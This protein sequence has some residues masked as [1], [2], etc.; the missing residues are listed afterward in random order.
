MTGFR[1]VVASTWK[2][3]DP[4][5]PRRVRPGRTAQ[6]LLAAGA[7]AV[8]VGMT[9]PLAA[10]A[11][12]VASPTG[13]VGAAA[14]SSPQTS[15]AADAS[16]TAANIPGWAIGPFTPSAANPLLTPSGSGYQAAALYNP[17]VLYRD[18]QYKMLYRGQGTYGGPSQIGY[19]SS[20]DGVHFTEDTAANPVINFGTTGEQ[21]KCGLEDPRLLELQGTY[22]TF[23][24]SVHP[25]ADGTCYGSYDISESTS[26]DG[27]HWST[28]WIVEPNAGSN[29]DAAVVT[30]ANGTPTKV[31]GEYVMYF[32]QGDTGTDIAY[33]TDMRTWHAK[34]STTAQ[35]ADPLNVHYP[36]GWQPYEVSVAVTDY[37][38]VAGRPANHDIVVFTAGTLM[39]NSRWFYAISEEEF[40]SQD[41]TQVLHQLS[42]A[43]LTPTPDVSY[44]WNGQTPKTVWMNSI[45]FHNGTWMM[46]YGAGDTVTALATAGLRQPSATH[47]AQSPQTPFQTGFEHGQPMPDWIDSVD[48]APG[49]GGSA[50]V[51]AYSGASSPESSVRQ[52]NNHDGTNALMYSGQATGAPDDHAYMKLFDLSDQPVS[53]GRDTTLSY[54]IYPQANGSAAPGVSGDNSSCVALDLVF[55]DGSALHELGASTLTPASQCGKL[56]LNQWNKVSVDI[57]KASAG[58]KIV[59]I[60]LG[61]DQPGSSGGYRG[62]VDDI[63][64]TNTA[65]RPATISGITPAD[66]APGQRVTI[67]GTGFGATSHGRSLLLSDAGV[68][69]GGAGDLGRL[70]IDH[71]SDTSV[72][73]TVPEPSGPAI[74]TASGPQNI[75]RVEPGST[76]SV[77]VITGPASSSNAGQFDVADTDV[78]S[79]YFNDVG[80]SPDTNRGCGALDDGTDAYSAD[81][82]AAASP[83]PLVP[84]ASLTV[85]GLGFTWPDAKSCDNDNVRALGQTILLPPEAGASE[86]GFLGAGTNGNQS[87]VATIHYTDGS[88]GTVT[89]KQSDWG[90]APGAGNTEVAEMAYRNQALGQQVHAF[91]VDE[92]VVSVDATRTVASITLPNDKNIHIFAMA[93][94]GTPITG[95]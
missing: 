1:R 80:I 59:R 21:D 18:G 7:I 78:L 27:I 42:D 94:N 23:F 58:K 95:S 11:A 72:T 90:G 82:L 28:P 40:S 22:Y 12:G 13:S 53:V 48:A 46:Y 8:A 32:G 14:P 30:D 9:P 92:Q 24:T 29:K 51:I 36:K 45:F 65:S 25:K 52:E 69:W 39:A 56:Q 83:N 31:N 3:P 43:V 54:W 88:T 74:S 16:Y 20:T 91:Y 26:T 84:G 64:L 68:D 70:T 5:R 62:Y 61:Y 66:A 41:P 93:Q 34:D 79:D 2:N 81:A 77:E 73:F 87:G 4:A 67:T 15:A 63:A 44:E 38:T 75:W 50:N 86:I 49:G 47:S 89:L 19:A 17:G 71:W 6:R 37:Q 55:A 57:G 35:T 85:N 10:T 33:S 60:D 76:A